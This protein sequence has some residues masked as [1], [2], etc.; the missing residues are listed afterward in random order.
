MHHR[1]SRWWSSPSRFASPN[2]LPQV[3]HVAGAPSPQP[4]CGQ[5]F[6][7]PV[8]RRLEHVAHGLVTQRLHVDALHQ[9]VLPQGGDRLG[10]RL[11]G[12]QRRQQ[13]DVTLGD[14]LVDHDGR[15]LVE[16]LSVVDHHERKPA[17]SDGGDPGPDLGGR[18][19]AVIGA[20]GRC[21]QHG[22]RAERDPDGGSAGDHPH[23]RPASW[24]QFPRNRQR[25]AGLADAR[26]SRQQNTSPPTDKRA[27][28][29]RSHCPAHAEARSSSPAVSMPGAG[30]AA[31]EHLVSQAI[32]GLDDLID[33]LW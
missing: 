20:V 3:Q 5:R 6:D 30:S 10:G 9:A 15:R 7:R 23:H 31:S 32:D 14:E 19:H 2:E 21:E 26:G 12:P 27:P 22:E 4:R 24:F 1:P 17:G 18:R 33:Q 16:P 13:G 28:G 8:E 29:Q 25:E 11:T